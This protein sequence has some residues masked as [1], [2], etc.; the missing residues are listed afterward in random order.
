MM[1]K[2]ILTAMVMAFVILP[3]FSQQDADKEIARAQGFTEAIMKQGAEKINALKAYIQKYPETSN[4]WTC[5]AYYNLATEYF[6]AKDYPQAVQTGEKA[7]KMNLGDG[8]HAR[9]LLVIANCYGIKSA[10]IYNLEKA[11][12]YVDKAIAF[13]DSKGQ[14][15]VLSEARNLKT[16]LSGPAPK[17][18]SPEDDVKY[19]A[20]LSDWPAVI[21]KYQKLS[22][23]SKGNEELHKLYASA[24]SKENKFDQALS[25]YQALLGK[26][27]KATYALNIAEIFEEKAKRNKQLTDNAIDAYLDAHLLF[28]KEGNSKNGKI[29]KDKARYMLYEKYGLN[30]KIKKINASSSN[31]QNAAEKNKA[32]IARLEKEYRKEERRIR[33]T[34]TDNDLEAPAYET[35]KLTKLQKKINALKSGAPAAGSKAADEAKKLQDEINKTDKELETLLV[36]AKKRLGL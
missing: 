1:K 17:Q 3:C 26:F 11:Q 29:A 16:K 13:A 5:L 14:E 31:Q 22:G 2:F 33:K 25:E 7:L 18:I 27:K 23:A 6:Q 15:D 35:D 32:E 21:T 20:S 12:E 19:S 36:N 28:M 10:S 9:L 8:E 34:Y 30:D 4:K 24:L